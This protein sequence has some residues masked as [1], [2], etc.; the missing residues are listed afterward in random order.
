M[1]FSET[2]CTVGSPPP[3]LGE[4]TEEVLRAVAGYSDE[5][6]ERLRR[7]SAI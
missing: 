3:R 5:E 6:I 7:A 1:K 2:P 4:H